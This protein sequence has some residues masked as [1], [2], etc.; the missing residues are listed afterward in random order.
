[1]T[2]PFLSLF[3]PTFRRPQQLAACIASVQAQTLAARIHHV[4]EPD[5]VGLGVGGMFARLATRPPTFYGEYVMFLGDDDVL[6]AKNAVARL[7]QIV[8][9][10]D[11]PD[12][13][14]VSTEKGHHGR[15]PY[16]NHG[17]PVCGRIDLNCVVTR[18]DIWNLHAKDY[19]AGTYEADFAHVHAMF[20]AG[21]RFH[22]AAELL[23]SRG[24]VSGGR[25]E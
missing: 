23:L 22:W 4:I 16:E 11:H 21:R 13:V 17:P 12:V 25:A 15:L 18:R 2:P 19:G 1:M 7:E 6:A 20:Q 9:D 10:S 14:I 24:A 3:T 5:Y 8:R